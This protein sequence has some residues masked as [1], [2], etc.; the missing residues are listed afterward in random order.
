MSWRYDRDTE[1]TLFSLWDYYLFKLIFLFKY[2]YFLM[3]QNQIDFQNLHWIPAKICIELQEN[4]I[5]LHLVIFRGYIWFWKL[6]KSLKNFQLHQKLFDWFY[7]SKIAFLIK[8]FKWWQF[9]MILR[10]MADLRVK[11]LK[12]NAKNSRK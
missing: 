12:K 11:N 2:W 9:Q 4:Y 8:I 6:Q 5:K 3:I 10:K 7:S 1:T